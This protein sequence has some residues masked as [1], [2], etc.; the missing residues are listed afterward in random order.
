MKYSSQLWLLLAV[1]AGPMLLSENASAQQ[2]SSE[3]VNVKIHKHSIMVKPDGAPKC[4]YS[5]NLTNVDVEFP[6]RLRTPGSYALRDGQVH[7]RQVEVKE[8]DG[9]EIECG[10]DLQFFEDEYTN[11]GETDIVV[12]VVGTDVPEDATLCYE[13]VVEDIGTIDPRARVKESFALNGNYQ[14]ELARLIGAY[15]ILVDS[16][17]GDSLSGQSLDDFIQDNY[18]MTEAEARELIQRLDME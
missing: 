13:I 3:K 7:V 15:D 9:S 10:T 4:L 1:I 14:A 5:P 12:R 11:T 17:M 16:N 8:V 2:C 6:I 18:D